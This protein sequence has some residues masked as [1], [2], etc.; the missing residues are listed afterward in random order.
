MMANRQ[1]KQSSSIHIFVSH[2]ESDRD[3]AGALVEFL[4]AAL[5]VDESCVRCTSV[6]GHQLP[7]G[8][9]I[10]EQIIEDLNSTRVLIALLTRSSITSTWVMFEIG[11][12]WGSRTQT[13]MPILGPGLTY[14]DLPGPIRGYQAVAIDKPNA[15]IRLKDAM[16]QLAIE[17]GVSEKTGG[18]VEAK[19]AQFIEICRTWGNDP[20]LVVAPQDPPTVMA[21]YTDEDY[22][23]ILESWIGKRDSGDNRRVIKFA[24]VDAELGLPSSTA[25]RLLQKAAAKF[26]LVQVRSTDSTIIFDDGPA[27]GYQGLRVPDIW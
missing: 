16:R 22:L 17:I 19:L 14:D 4:L 13:I 6:P 7:F 9:T 26:N 24:E 25:K 23:S 15:T 20:N 2:R 11:A 8:T 10:S 12:A 21:D 1:V 18:K 3:I 5:S 27:P